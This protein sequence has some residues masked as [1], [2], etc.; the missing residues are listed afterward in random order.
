MGPRQD[1][2]ITPDNIEPGPGQSGPHSPLPTYA[3]SYLPIYLS[4]PPAIYLSRHASS[5]L[6]ICLGARVWSN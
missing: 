2:E 3:P 6:S 1:P 4:V 5:R